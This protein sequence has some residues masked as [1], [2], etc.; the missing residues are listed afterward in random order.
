MPLEDEFPSIDAG[1]TFVVPTY[2]WLVSR[3]EA[4]DNRLNQVLTLA[5]GIT[6]GLP[7]L[8]RAVRSDLSF[9]S[10]Y[11]LLAL[12]LFV[13]AAIVAL[14]ARVKGR[15]NLPNPATIYEQLDDQAARFK[16][17]AI[18]FAGEHYRLNAAV[19]ETKLTAAVVSMACV[20]L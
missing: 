7:A 14:V 10:A 20:T 15:V 12:G 2:T 9:T 18:Y 3:I 5:S 19:A 11:F 13:V 1:F 17:N 16:A 6:S 4:A 8:A